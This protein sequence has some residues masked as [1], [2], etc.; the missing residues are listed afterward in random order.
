MV[1]KALVQLRTQCG[2]GL[3]LILC[4]AVRWLLT[5]PSVQQSM[6]QHTR[7][8][9]LVLQQLQQPLRAQAQHQTYNR[10]R[11]AKHHWSFPR[12]AEGNQRT[13]RQQETVPRMSKHHRTRLACAYVQAHFETYT[14]L[15]A[16]NPTTYEQRKITQIAG[17]FVNHVTSV[18][19]ISSVA[20]SESGRKASAS[21]TSS[22]C[23][24]ASNLE[25][26]QQ[27]QGRLASHEKH[28]WPMPNASIG[29]T[30]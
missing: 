24:V 25:C 11:N 23:I 29:G 22:C 10:K 2:S 4:Y 18:N 3:V 28:L 26:S 17:H 7:A 27:A 21:S 12:N 6:I 9:T 13:P 19:G 1:C 8:T 20:S 15:L 14:W 16:S 5:R 30:W